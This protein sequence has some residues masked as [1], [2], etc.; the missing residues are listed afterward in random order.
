MVAGPPTHSLEP[1]PRHRP[2]ANHH[3]G[4]FMQIPTLMDISGTSEITTPSARF[5]CGSSEGNAWE[6]VE[7]SADMCPRICQEF[8]V[9]ERE[10]LGEWRWRQEYHCEFVEGDDQLF[11]HDAIAR[12]VS[13]TVRPLFGREAQNV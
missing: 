4:I 6:K 13:D 8:L 2:P 3:Q 9:E 7:I 11:G 12:A 1:K 10:A 5:S